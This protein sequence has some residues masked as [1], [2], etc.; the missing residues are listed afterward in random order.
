MAHKCPY[1]EKKF[2][3][4]MGLRR[5][6]IVTHMNGKCPACGIEA[7]VLRVHAFKMAEKRDKRHMV[8]LGLVGVRRWDT[9][10]KKSCYDMAEEVTRVL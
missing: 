9:E 4:F 2:D 3:S 5:H 8:L 10:L 1:C 7:R 6:V